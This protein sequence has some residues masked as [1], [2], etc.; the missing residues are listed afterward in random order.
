MMVAPRPDRSGHAPDCGRPAAAARR[1]SVLAA[2]TG[3]LA[4]HAAETR[5]RKAH[6]A[7]EHHAHDDAD[8]TAGTSGSASDKAFRSPVSSPRALPSIG[9]MNKVSPPAA[10]WRP[11]RRRPLPCRSP[12]T[13]FVPVLSPQHESGADRV[14]PG[15]P[16]LNGG[17][18]RDPAAR[19]SAAVVRGAGRRLRQRRGLQWRRGV[20]TRERLLLAAA[21]PGPRVLAATG[22]LLGRLAARLMLRRF[23]ASDDG[24]ARRR[25]RGRDLA[26]GHWQSLL[27]EVVC[28]W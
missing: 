7:A 19:R 17:S 14:I 9:P 20:V 26:V 27:R 5:A 8:G 21:R 22:G 11:W 6:Q 15:G 28:T 10:G 24:D 16:P 18:R 4:D 1:W 13:S 23:A 2:E 12:S 25:R 3:L